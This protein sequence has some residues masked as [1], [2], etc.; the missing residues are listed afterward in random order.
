MRASRL[1]MPQLRISLPIRHWREG[2]V[3]EPKVEKPP[4][5]HLVKGTFS[6]AAP[7]HDGARP[8]LPGLRL[9]RHEGSP[10]LPDSIMGFGEILLVPVDTFQVECSHPRLS[11]L[12]TGFS[13]EGKPLDICCLFWDC[14]WGGGVSSRLSTLFW[15]QWLSVWA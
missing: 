7:G 11:L 3:P 1:V 6:L 2:P 13:P 14:G 4:Q 15:K 8:T 5:E 12:A 10:G 9:W